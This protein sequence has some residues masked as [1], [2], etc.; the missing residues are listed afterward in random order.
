MEDSILYRPYIEGTVRQNS[1][2]GGGYKGYKSDTQGLFKGFIGLYFERR[3]EVLRV[4]SG[5]FRYL[6]GDFRHLAG[7]FRYRRVLDF[8]AD[9]G[10]FCY[11]ARDFRHLAGNF[12]YHRVLE[13]WEGSKYF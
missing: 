10:C 7:N 1:V 11:L 4:G 6:A 9:S 13:F 12:R 2:C 8:W 5:Y 3:S